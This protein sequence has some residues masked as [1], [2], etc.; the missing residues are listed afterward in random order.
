MRY[1]FCIFV[2]LLFAVTQAQYKQIVIEHPGLMGVN[3]YYGDD[4]VQPKQVR[5]MVNGDLHNGEIDKRP[6]YGLVGS[7]ADTIADGIFPYY[8]F[9]GNRRL[10]L[11]SC[12]RRGG[13]K[14]TG[15]I[16]YTN[17]NRFSISS[18]DSAIKMYGYVNPTFGYDWV[19]FENA[20]F[21]TNGMNHPIFYMEDEWGTL[22]IPTPGA[23]MVSVLN[24]TG[25]VNGTVSYKLHYLADT[26]ANDA[27]ANK[28]DTAQKSY[29]GEM[30]GYVFPSGKKVILWALPERPDGTGWDSA[31]VLITRTKADGAVYFVVDTLSYLKSDGL[32]Y[33]DNIADASLGDSIFIGD[34]TACNCCEDSILVP[35]QPFISIADSTVTAWAPAILGKPASYDSFYVGYSFFDTNLSIESEI[36][37]WSHRIPNTS[38]SGEAV[39]R[40]TWGA[41][42]PRLGK[43]FIDGIIVYCTY[44][45]GVNNGDSLSF[46]ALDTMFMNPADSFFTWSEIAFGNW[47]TK[48]YGDMDSTKFFN[49]STLPHPLTNKIPYKYIVQSN[50]RL[51][52]AG[53]EDYPCRLYYSG[54]TDTSVTG[55]GGIGYWDMFYAYLALDENDGDKIMGMVADEKGIVVYKA[56]STWYVTGTD[57]EYDMRYLKISGSIGAVSNN[58]IVHYANK[59]YFISPDRF[60]YE[61]TEM[62]MDTISGPIN[63]SFED[64]AM[65][66]LSA[67][68]ATEYR[69][70]IWFNT[71]DTIFIYNPSRQSWRKYQLGAKRFAYYDSIAT[72]DYVGKQNL[73]FSKPATDNIYWFDYDDTCSVDYCTA[74]AAA[75]RDSIRLIVK[76]GPYLKDGQYKIMGGRIEADIPST[77]SLLLRLLSKDDD[78]LCKVLLVNDGTYLDNIYDFHFNSPVGNRFHLVILDN[79][80]CA[81]LRI[82]R[83]ILD[84]VEY[85]KAG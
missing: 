6:G 59:D 34:S 52:A 8:S 64:L 51:W 57:P 22:S 67:T 21:M 53:D 38:G 65:S 73:V 14:D 26:S 63:D 29:P 35:G 46:R 2:F 74:A 44:D 66:V 5:D 85:A 27:A 70:E 32:I 10:L 19:Q 9:E 11:A 16:F 28:I 60:I 68:T 24:I 72:T 15:I 23:P 30:S 36:G 49:R 71:N 42:V 12:D 18:S 83:I 37:Y 3:S 40:T 43:N 84:Y 78:T 13:A 56:Y 82:K 47:W 48:G 45:A 41:I 62:K 55:F 77:D 7:G 76:L 79:G 58:A 1:W 50:G 80:A 31:H 4:F 81:T 54:R 20:L 39:G 25:N 75:D 33:V 61:R 69:G 17:P